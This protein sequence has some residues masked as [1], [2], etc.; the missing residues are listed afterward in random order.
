M[1]PSTHIQPIDYLKARIA[2]DIRELDEQREA[3][4]ITQSGGTLAVMQL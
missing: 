3:L 1:K 4:I 2:E